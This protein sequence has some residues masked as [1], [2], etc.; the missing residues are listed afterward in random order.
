MAGQDAKVKAAIAANLWKLY[1][2]HSQTLGEETED[3]LP[4]ASGGLKV[5]SVEL[6][7]GKLAMQRTGGGKFIAL[8][9]SNDAAWEELFS[10]LVALHQH[11]SSLPDGL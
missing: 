2:K 10:R 4:D 8:V 1:E 9:S 3:A 5:L 11:L 7:N 6:E